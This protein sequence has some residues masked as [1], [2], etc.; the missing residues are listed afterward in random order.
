[1]SD[2]TES[3]SIRV[4]KKLL[5]DVEDFG[6]RNGLTNRTSACCLAFSK[7]IENDQLVQRQTRLLE[8]VSMKV[9]YTLRS[10]AMER[11]SEF[12]ASI[13]EEYALKLGDI[14][15]LIFEFGMDYTDGDRHV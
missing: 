6:H 8:L 3:I 2:E 14:E 4:P 5:K 12:V 9:L 11:G 15:Q 13:D 1:M 7:A 10:I